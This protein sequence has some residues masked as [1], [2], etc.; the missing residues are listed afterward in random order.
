MGDFSAA[1]LGAARQRLRRL[2]RTQIWPVIGSPAV[3]GS[4]NS[5]KLATIT[6]FSWVFRHIH[7]SGLNPRVLA[8]R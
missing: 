1:F 8:L 3:S 4:T 7:G 5:C 6:S 2:L